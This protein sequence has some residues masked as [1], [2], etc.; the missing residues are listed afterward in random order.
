M[1]DRRIPGRIIHLRLDYD[2]CPVQ[3]S[4][5]VSDLV[6]RLQAILLLM[7]AVLFG[8]YFSLPLWLPPLVQSQL[9]QGWQLESL[10]VEYP[11]SSTLHVNSIV[12]GNN[13][14]GNEIQ[15][16]AQDLK[17]DIYQPSL[18]VSSMNV[19]IDL[20]DSAGKTGPFSIDDLRVPL[21]IRPGKLP[22]ISIDSLRLDLQIN[23]LPD[24]SWLFE[25]LQLDTNDPSSGRLKSTLPLPELEGLTGLIEIELLD[26][27]LEAKFQLEQADRNKVLEIKFSQ[28]AGG[29]E[30]S[31]EISGQAQLQALQPLLLAILSELDLLPDQLRRIQGHVSFEAYFTGRKEQTLNR[32][33]VRARNLR[34][35]MEDKNLELEMDVEL[36]RERNG[37]LINFLSPAVFHFDAENDW[38]SGRLNE[39][40]PMTQGDVHSTEDMGEDLDL[41]IDALS[42]I[43]LQTSAPFPA[44]FNGG[45]S[46]D[47]SSSLLDLSLELGQ[48]ARFQI[49]DLMAPQ[50]LT[51]SGMINIKLDTKRALALEAPASFSVPLGASLSTQG[52][53]ALD[54][55][56]IRF[57]ES[58]D[59]R[60]FTPRLMVNSDSEIIDFHDLEISGVTEFLVPVTGDEPA[61][62][63]RYNGHAQSKAFMVSHSDSGQ[64]PQV[65]IDSESM[66]LKLDFS[67]SAEQ[68][69]SSGTGTLLNMKMDSS[70]LSASELNI[71]WNALD[72]LALTGEFR[73]HTR[74]LVISHEDDVYKGIDL[75][76]TFALLPGNHINGHGDIVLAGDIR[77]PIE[78]N[79][80]LGSDDW[81]INVPPL[82]LSLQQAAKAL[83]I[84]NGSIPDQLQL[85]GGT[86][87]FTANFKVGNTVQ[88]DMD[89]NG[90]G[91][92]LSL[93]ESSVDGAEFNISLNLNET[94][95]GSGSFLV[96]RLELAAG[97]NLFQIRA[98]IVQMTPE[99]IDL[100]D[101]DAE[102]FGGHLSADRIQLSP[103]GLSHTQIKL[104]G[105]DL[106]QVLDYI[107]VGGLQGSG[108]IE[109]SLPIGSQGSS[110]YVQNGVFRANGPGILKYSGSISAASAENIGLSA[111]E[112]FYF[113]ELDGTIDYNPDGSYRLKIHLAG[114][115]PDL[116]N[117]YPISLK[118]NIG[119]ML[120][121]AFEVLFLTGDFNQAILNQIRRELLD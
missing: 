54:G 65:L 20:T 79:G 55:N 75:D 121:E 30:I 53:L 57:D 10:V 76:L 113:T 96:D 86:I 43:E 78:F 102:F 114:S 59:F 71:E 27:I 66:D 26:E 47:F 92:S 58:K 1:A 117:G 21:I 108:D 11:Y 28:T 73:T 116:Y 14:E 110:L 97:L 12:V 90:K 103:Q 34:V 61:T 120:P 3:V 51:G 64:A 44:G 37:V 36:N 104:T 62:E 41:T 46:L 17:I 101:F 88:G 67:L 29:G 18:Q 106:G 112:N 22:P 49:S 31:S 40:L 107:D 68:L 45:V 9:T 70:G 98:L 42:R 60:V 74:G 16:A 111:L 87:D 72:P 91:L 39:L 24:K 89:I 32:V 80:K 95:E 5:G 4:L 82:Q 85:A 94:L 99:S 77:S 118:L 23:G 83:E 2:R 52:R 15:V 7:A 35:E 13:L 33:H 8:S 119:G 6:R 38:V 63:F 84:V 81:R 50:S 115:N 109:I 93:A 105:I 56:T 19:S 100:Q 25:D 48:D 69:L